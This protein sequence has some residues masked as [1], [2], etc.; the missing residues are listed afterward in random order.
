MNFGTGNQTKSWPP[1]S[2]LWHDAQGWYTGSVSHVA[3][4]SLLAVSEGEYVTA[5][6]GNQK[7]VG[8]VPTSSA[9][10]NTTVAPVIFM[11][12]KGGVSRA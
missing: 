6:L 3:A 7:M 10:Q 8:T 2:E 1:A 4:C 11:K 5:R 9:H 12:R